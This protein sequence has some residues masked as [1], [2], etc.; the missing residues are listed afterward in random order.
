MPY[1]NQYADKSSH[2]DIVQNPEVVEFIHNCSYMVEPTE[3][4][5]E[6]L[7][8][9]FQ[10]IPKNGLPLPKHVISVDGSSYEASINNRFPSTKLGYIKI[11]CLLIDRSQYKNLRVLNNRFVD[12]FKVARMQESNRATTFTVPSS[13]MV[14]KGCKNVQASFRCAM[15]EQFYR[16]RTIQNEP[17]S[18]LRTTLF[19]MAAMRT[20]KLGTNNPSMLKLHKC[21]NCDMTELEV[22]DVPDEQNCPKCGEPVYPTDCLRIWEE[23]SEHMSNTAPITRLMNVI[24]HLIPVHYIRIIHDFEQSFFVNILENLAFF[25]DGPLAVFGTPAWL[26]ASILRFIN[27]INDELTQLGKHRLVIIG[28]QKSGAVVEYF[29]LIDRL[30]PAGRI[31]AVDDDFR[32]KYITPCNRPSSNGFGYE[33]YY[34][35]DFVLK[36]ESGRIFVFS[37]PYPFSGKASH[38]TFNFVKEKVKLANYSELGLAVNLICDFECDLYEHAVVPIALAHKYTA[39]S[40]EPGSKVLDLLSRE[41]FNGE[42]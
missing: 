7:K 31:F 1:R 14:Y 32:Y 25:V 42:R 29:N 3:K 30:I 33:T 37:L 35:Q 2:I 34:G 8:D 11:G 38:S 40:L 20:G 13:N 26:H 10:D 19:H 36:T 22:Y 41:Y 15:D 12:P 17:S 5:R 24:E 4:E 23:V 39:I 9:M 27:K 16:L 28:L 6:Q 21:P 18:S